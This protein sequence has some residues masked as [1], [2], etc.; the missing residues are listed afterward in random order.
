LLSYCQMS[1]PRKDKR[2]DI[3][4]KVR[5]MAR[6]LVG[7]IPASRPIEPKRGR[8]KPKHKKSPLDEL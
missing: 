2:T 5:R 6:I 1:G 7:T 8:K 3:R 4:R